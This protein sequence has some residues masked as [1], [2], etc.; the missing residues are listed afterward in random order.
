MRDTPDE[1]CSF[2]SLTLYDSLASSHPNVAPFHRSMDFGR[3]NTSNEW[4]NRLETSET[5]YKLLEKEECRD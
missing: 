5:T 1:E 4:Q 2:V 3:N